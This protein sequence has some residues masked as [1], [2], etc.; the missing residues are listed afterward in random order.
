M[1]YSEFLAKV[2]ALL[3]QEVNRKGATEFAAELITQGIVSLIASVEAYRKGRVTTYLPGDLSVDRF[4]SVGNLPTGCEPREIFLIRS[5]Q[6]DV[7]LVSAS[8][9]LVTTSAA[10][11]ISD[12]TTEDV[13]VSG[14]FS[15][16]GTM[17]GGIV[18]R[19]S[20]FL[21]PVSDTQLSIHAT[22]ADAVSGENLIDITS[23]GS[24]V[25][26]LTHSE[27]RREMEH[28]DWHDRHSLI[29][30]ETCLNN[31]L[32]KVC[33]EPSGSTFYVYPLLQEIDANG[34]TYSIELNWDGVS[35]DWED[36]DT[37]PFIDS[38]AL[39][40]S[41]FVRSRMERTVKNDL[42]MAASYESTFRKGKGDA[43][44]EASLRTRTRR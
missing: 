10:H 30:G 23:S 33:I 36:T 12:P 29:L 43:Y 7:S 15:T 31:D 20:Y 19:R 32:P 16:S 22:A 40:V 14:Y 27:D 37:V 17:P 34:F 28:V 44:I 21:K 6:S 39:T 38:D 42:T 3:T 2:R 35:V 24:G 26:V 13:A 9:D 41:D 8:T 1:T 5:K 18:E 11:G 4:T 25:I